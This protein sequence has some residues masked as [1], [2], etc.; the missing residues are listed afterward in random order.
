LS[1]SACEQT[2][3]LSPRPTLGRPLFLDVIEQQLLNQRRK[4]AMIR[5]S[6]L[7]GK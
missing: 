1:I 7:L 3:L 5:S 6:S 4:R 2:L